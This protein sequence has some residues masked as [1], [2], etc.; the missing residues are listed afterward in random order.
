MIGLCVLIAVGQWWP[1]FWQVSTDKWVVF[2]YEVK[3]TIRD[4]S[5]ILQKQGKTSAEIKKQI[6]EF[7]FSD[8][9]VSYFF[10]V[11]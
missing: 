10:K 3:E 6:L 11:E 8:E 4:V 5:K 7:G 2:P 9:Q 1:D